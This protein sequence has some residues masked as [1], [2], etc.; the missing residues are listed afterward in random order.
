MDP[1]RVLKEDIFLNNVVFQSTTQ[2]PLYLFAIWMKFSFA[3]VRVVGSIEYLYDPQ[4][5]VPGLAICVYDFKI[6]M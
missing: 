2:T 5:V 4:I 3:A 6:E 1:I